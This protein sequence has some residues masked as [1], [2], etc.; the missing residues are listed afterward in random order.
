MRPDHPLAELIISAAGGEF[1]DADGGWRRV[2]PWRAGLEAIVSFTGH[3]VFA[4]R[5]D[6]PDRLLAALGADGFGGAHDPRLITALAGPDGWIDSLD[7]LMASRGTG[8]AGVTPRLTDRP[9]LATHPRAMFAAG[10]RDHPRL[11]GYPD[12]R[13]SALA[14]VSGGIAGLTEVSFELEPSRRRAGGGAELVRDALSATPFRPA[15]CGGSRA[16]QRGQRP[17][18]AGG[19]VRSAGFDPAVPLRRSPSQRL[20]LRIPPGVAARHPL[21]VVG[22]ARDQTASGRASLAAGVSRSARPERTGP[23]ARRQGSRLRVQAAGPPGPVAD[24]MAAA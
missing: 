16:W 22:A 18:A 23:A 3:A 2:P 21:A 9:D 6:V 7:M 14:V 1:P 13:R 17:G 15:C 4:V 8:R 19:R 20:S 12:P 24:F 10:I 11:M 5:P